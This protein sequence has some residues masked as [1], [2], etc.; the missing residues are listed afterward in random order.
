MHQY[1]DF[2]RKPTITFLLSSIKKNILVVLCFLL[3]FTS[4]GF[5]YLNYVSNKAYQSVGQIQSS[6]SLTGTYL[7]TIIS[8]IK[9]EETLNTIEYE[10]ENDNIT[11]TDGSKVSKNEILSGLLIPSTNSSSFL[12]ITYTSFDKTT[13]QIVLQQIME[14]SIEKILAGPQASQYPNLTIASNASE[15]QDISNIEMKMFL[16]ALFGFLVGSCAVFIV[17]LKMDLISEKEDISSLNT[18]V[19][20][21]NFD[22]KEKR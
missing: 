15:P 21:L 7:N 2:E 16:F 10:L 4:F 18:N 14:T 19:F 17:D 9:D 8:S 1:K 5:V 13:V 20:E 3:F 6:R 11:H 22:T 12:K